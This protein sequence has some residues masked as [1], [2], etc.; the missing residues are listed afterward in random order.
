MGSTQNQISSSFIII[1]TVTKINWKLIF[2]IHTFYLRFKHY[3]KLICTLRKLVSFL[4]KKTVRE[5]IA[6]CYLYKRLIEW[7]NPFGCFCCFHL[8]CHIII[9]H[10]PLASLFNPISERLHIFFSWLIIY[11]LLVFIGS[12]GNINLSSYI[13]DG[14]NGGG[15]FKSLFVNILGHFSLFFICFALPPSPYSL[16]ASFWPVFLYFLFV[17]PKFGLFFLFL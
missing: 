16:F 2:P 13:I 8:R 7:L 12:L 5:Y 15:S 9:W 6:E 11:I 17:R 4:L 1:E 14:L 10:S 3:P